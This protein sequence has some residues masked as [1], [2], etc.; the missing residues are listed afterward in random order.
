MNSNKIFKTLF[1]MLVWTKENF[2][3]FYAVLFDLVEQTH[4]TKCV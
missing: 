3:K 2:H 1:I 4:K